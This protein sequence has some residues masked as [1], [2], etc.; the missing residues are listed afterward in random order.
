VVD[1]VYQLDEIAD[2]H[3]RMESNASFGKVV[4]VP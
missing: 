4:I 1:R 2:A 3:R